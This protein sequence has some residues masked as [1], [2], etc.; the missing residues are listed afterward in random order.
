M[1]KRDHHRCKVVAIANQKGGVGKTTTAVNLAAGLAMLKRQVLL[2][3]CDAQANATSGIGVEP[4][5]LSLNLFHLLT[6][7]ASINQVI[8]NTEHQGLSILPASTEL[9]GVEMELAR[10]EGREMVLKQVLREIREEYDF[11]VLDCPPSLGLITVNALSA[12]DSVIIPLQC[13]YYA[14]EGLSQLVQSIRAVKHSLNPR[15]HI[16]GILLTMYD[17][18]TRLG[19]QVARE[20]RIHFRDLVYR[21][22]IPRNIRLSESPSHGQPIFQYDPR[23]K[24][25]ESYLSFAKEFLDKNRRIS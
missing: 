5:S 4:K 2:V 13:E 3:D 20:V 23:S 15:L 21:T 19:F 7:R 12:A 11:V 17:N 6:M 10:T 14:L 8:M 9:V 24:G 22:T 16:E 1:E 25:A 18:R